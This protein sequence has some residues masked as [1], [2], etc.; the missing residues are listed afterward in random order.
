MNL[1]TR[2]VLREHGCV[3]KHYN[4]QI[5]ILI[6]ASL[7]QPQKGSLNKNR[8]PNGA[9]SLWFPAIP[10]TKKH[11]PTWVSTHVALHTRLLELT[12]RMTRRRRRR[13]S[14]RSRRKSRRRRRAPQ[15][16]LARNGDGTLSGLLFFYFAFVRSWSLGFLVSKFQVLPGWP[17]A[18]NFQKGLA[19]IWRGAVGIACSESLL[20]HGFTSFGAF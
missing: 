2:G 7:Y 13:S 11:K 15:V 4:N 5:V 10:S 16:G 1:D 17:F 9:F 19:Q 20:M 18:C 8:N 6:L 14:K 12:R 3:L